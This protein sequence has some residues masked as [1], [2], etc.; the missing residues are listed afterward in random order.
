M[1]IL[2]SR[3]LCITEDKT[4]QEIHLEHSRLVSKDVVVVRRGQW[5]LLWTGRNYTNLEVSFGGRIWSGFVASIFCTFG[6]YLL[7]H[8]KQGWL[9]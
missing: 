3:S 1:V 5:D 2:E 4:K 8:L 7:L 6:Q 9:K